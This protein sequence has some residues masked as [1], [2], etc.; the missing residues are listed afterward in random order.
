MML[1]L[2]SGKSSTG[3]VDEGTVVEWWHWS[4]GDE[5]EEIVSKPCTE[6]Y[7]IL[8]LDKTMIISSEYYSFDVTAATPCSRF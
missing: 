5:I 1:F 6:Q 7:E 8:F 3:R 2:Y 4:N